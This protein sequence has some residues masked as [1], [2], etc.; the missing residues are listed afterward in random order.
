MASKLRLLLIF[1][2]FLSVNL[3]YSQSPEKEAAQRQEVEGLV[4]FYKY[5]LNT[6]GD[7][8]SSQRNKDVIITQS[9]KKAFRDDLVQIEDDLVEDRM[10][11]TNKNVKA[12][13]QDV[14]F[15]FEHAAFEFNEVLIER[16][17]GEGGQQYYKVSFNSVLK[18]K[19]IDGGAVNRAQKR[20]MEIN[21]NEE[22][23]DLKIVS[24]YT[25]KVD[26][27]KELKYWWE[28]LS[29]SWRE[30]FLTKVVLRDSVSSAFL[31]KVASIDSL[32]LT[33]GS[34]FLDLNP[35]AEIRGLKYL[36]ISNTSVA[37]LEPIRSLNQ[38]IHLEAVNCPIS[39]LE[40][41]K[42]ANK[43]KVLNLSNTNVQS[44]EL[45][46]AIQGME[47]L[48][49]SGTY[50]RDFSALNQIT[51]LKN[52][53]LSKTSFNENTQLRG[54]SKLEVLDISNTDL[55]RWYGVEL[56]GLQEI[57]LSNTAVANLEGFS[58][59]KNLREIRI[60]STQ[61]SDISPLM[62]IASV[63]KIYC[64][65]T[66]VT[67]A[68]VALFMKKR[69][70]VVVLNNSKALRNWWES[71]NTNWKE[72]F[73]SY[74]GNDAY[75]TQENLVRLVHLDS[76][77][78][79]NQRL[80]DGKPLA[81]LKRLKYLNISNNLFVD[82]KFLREMSDLEVLVADDLPVEDISVISKLTELSA[83]SYK[84]NLPID[85]SHLVSLRN[86]V[87]LNMDG[88][89]LD[90]EQVAQLLSQNESLVLIY[91]SEALKSWWTMLNTPWQ[92]AFREIGQFDTPDDMQLH[93]LVQSRKLALNSISANSI[94]PLSN[95]NAIKILQISNS[96]ISDLCPLTNLTTLEQ[97]E[98]TGCPVMSPHPIGQLGNL[99]YLDV[100]NTPI[101]S[102]K[103]FSKLKRLKYLN[104][105][106]TNIKN[107]KGLEGLYDLERLNLA[108]TNVWKLQELYEVQSLKE[109]IC[110]NTRLRSHK[111]D[112]FRLVNPDCA[113]TFY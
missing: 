37:S 21:F 31:M 111:I 87:L 17:E 113:I 51:E 80:L 86:L 101:K 65:D 88:N 57:D 69:S 73:R 95:F 91:Q 58:T 38:L 24:V 100:S 10:V 94:E 35:L 27:A 107:L 7:S 26:R 4:N 13:L 63:K 46:G 59:L 53:N 97:L 60:N 81:R 106:G 112:E 29:V 71:L 22:K 44:I 89:K 109:L 72:V 45:L 23:N 15:F 64:D 2:F 84:S 67:E 3:G 66:K 14:D 36:D 62:S 82:L 52:L 98:I 40:Y 93:R 96:P 43:L 25:T 76:L 102:L 30:L 103:T 61:V 50:V 12:Y 74:A 55:S 16:Q 79:S 48:N 32:T 54:L 108:N 83:F 8:Q 18:G 85:I 77:D 110:F 28:N 5:I 11:V 78:L 33:E 49:L 75:P 70:D 34:F 104:C 42:Y 20:F 92:N 68:Q 99:T 39:K 9:Y 90:E 19:G 105:S 6:L 41:L 56:L 1:L 47:V